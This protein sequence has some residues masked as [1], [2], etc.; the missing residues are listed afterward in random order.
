MAKSAIR[1]ELWLFSALKIEDKAGG[2]GDEL[3][4]FL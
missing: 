1:D 3:P 2:K 4:P